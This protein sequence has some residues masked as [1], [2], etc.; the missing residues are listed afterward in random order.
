MEVL[1]ELEPKGEGVYQLSIIHSWFYTAID[2]HTAMNTTSKWLG[3]L[4]VAFVP[5]SFVAS[6]ELLDHVLSFSH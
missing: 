6:P 4:A 5:G 1:T 2:Y 3:L